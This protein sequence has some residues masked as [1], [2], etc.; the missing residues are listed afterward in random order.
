MALENWAGNYRY[1]AERV[2]RP[3]TVAQVQ[4]LV[5][6]SRR[7]KALGTRHSFNA[8]ADSAEDLI[9][10]EGLDKIVGIDRERMTVTIEGGVTYGALCPYLND[11]GFAI[12]NLASLPHISVAGGCATGTH[13]SGDGSGNLATAVSGMEVVVADG[14]IVEF[15]RELNGAAAHLGGLGIVV[16]LALNIRPAFTMRQEVYENLPLEAATERF[17]EIMSSA[18]SVSL[19]T[20]W[21]KSVIDQVWIKRVE[22]GAPLEGAQPADANRHPIREKSPVNC[23]E[24]TGI[25]GPWHERLPHF[26][27]DYMPSSGK[28]LQ[29][30]YLMPRE[31]AADALRAVN[32]LSGL[33]TPIL[34]ISEIRTVAADEL[35]MSPSY[36]RPS[37]A[38]HFTWRKDWEAVRAALPV[39]E[40]ALVPFQPR[41]HWGKLFCASPE[42]LHAVYPRIGDFRALLESYDPKGKFRNS[43]L[44]Q[45]IWPGQPT[46]V[47][48]QGEG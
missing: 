21:Q 35:W 4:E 47:G 32:G 7:A 17:D 14:S 46:E 19:F 39:I 31:C 27:M 29:S 8:I 34:Q 20:H 18:Y 6:A 42:R 48:R 23:T 2:H 11:R 45:T 15:T 9:S 10:L 44:E 13:G 22:D 16:R 26:R 5:A 28:E 25:P 38:I 3:E 30:E 33:L 40:E 41:P 1:T 36:Q 43:F 12:H 24:Q 37:V